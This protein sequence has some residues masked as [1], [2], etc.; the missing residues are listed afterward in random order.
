MNNPQKEEYKYEAVATSEEVKAELNNFQVSE[1]NQKIRETND[2]AV[3]NWGIQ[4]IAVVIGTF[5]AISDGM[6]YGWTSP[7]IP[8]FLSNETHINVT[9]SEG[10]F[11][12]TI[13]LLGAATGLPFTILGVEYLGRKKSMILSAMVGCLCWIIILVSNQLKWIYTAR[14]FSGMAGDMCFVAAPMYVAEIADHRIR[15]FLSALIYIMMLIGIVTV[16]AVGAFLPYS[17]VPCI[18]IVLTICQ[19]IFFP[20]FPESP[21]Y[22]I[23]KNKNKSARKSLLRFRAAS[24]ID[25]EFHEIEKAIERQK[26][27][28]GRPQDLILI[29]S[30]RFALLIMIILNGVQHFVGISVIIMNLHIILDEAGSIYIQPSTAAIMFAAIMLVSAIIASSMIDKFGRKF[31]LVVSGV[32]TGIALSVMTVY[33][34]LKNLNYDVISVSWIPAACVMIYAFTFKIGMGL[35]PIVVTAEIF[36]AS[37]KAIG[38]TVADVAYVIAGIIAISVYSL[39]YDNFGIHVPFYMFSVCSFLTVFFTIFVLPETKGKTLEEIQLMLKGKAY[40]NE[41]LNSDLK[42]DVI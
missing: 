10:E 33:F 3:T 15:G 25:E 32:L 31:L 40:E 14:F 36:P 26:T 18:G 39:L 29:R 42:N 41:K 24:T 34:H 6:T 37:I 23:Y 28:K 12:E 22:L 30:N 1:N 38:M 9:K 4:V 5:M 16:Y 27:E 13:V 7:M 2:N 20:F 35:V 11:M 17:V 19:C 21:Y 8:Y